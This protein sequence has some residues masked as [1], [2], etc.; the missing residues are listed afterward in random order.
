[1]NKEQLQQNIAKYYAKLPVELQQF[2]SSMEWMRILNNISEKYSLNEEQISTLG[3]ETT[4]LLLGIVHADEYKKTLEKNINLPKNIFE[5]MFSEID[6]S[7]LKNIYTELDQAFTINVDSLLEEKYGGDKKLDER[8]INLPKEVQVAI[9]ESNYQVTLYSIAEKYKLNVEQMGVLEEITTKVMLG[10]VHP[11]KYEEELALKIAIPR[12]SISSVVNDVNDSILKT[13]REILKKHWDENRV[14]K[15]EELKIR[16]ENTPTIKKDDDVP[17]PPYA[18]PEIKEI[19]K[20]IEKI[21]VAKP[22]QDVIN[23][24]KNIL[25]EKLNGP[26]VSTHVVSDYSKNKVSS[27]PTQVNNTNSPQK[28]HDPYREEF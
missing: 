26:T 20:P 10:M 15:N 7:I 6:N 17:L 21:E 1:M 2:F 24:T 9:N 5:T 8:F 11:D 23:T 14:I 12:N 16:N 22:V 18:R 19:Q 4:I 28:S 13:I 25:E 27:L 3:T